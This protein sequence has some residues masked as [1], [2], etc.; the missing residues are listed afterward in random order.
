MKKEIGLFVVLFI[1]SFALTVRAQ[2]PTVVLLQNIAEHANFVATYGSYKQFSSGQTEFGSH[3][4]VVSERAQA[5]LKAINQ[6]ITGGVPESRTIEVRFQDG[7]RTMALSEDRKSTRLNS[8]H[9]QKSRM[10]S[11]A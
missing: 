7:N 2:V 5:C 4:D 8:S 6:A 1:C 10:P 3:S 11:S 9:I